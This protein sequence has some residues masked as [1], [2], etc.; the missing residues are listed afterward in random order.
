[1]HRPTHTRPRIFRRMHPD[2]AVERTLDDMMDERN[3]IDVGISNSIR[4]KPAVAFIGT[5]YSSWRKF[6][7]SRMCMEFNRKNNG[8]T[9]LNAK[10]I[11]EKKKKEEESRLEMKALINE[12][13]DKLTFKGLCAMYKLVRKFIREL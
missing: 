8:A 4:A 6:E 12:D 7:E 2:V 9:E 13:L 10:E 11:E 5:S 1:M 3:V